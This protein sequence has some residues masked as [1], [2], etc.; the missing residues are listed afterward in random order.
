MLTK[1]NR[2]MNSTTT[3]YD[4]NILLDVKNV[5][6]LT[7]NRICRVLRKN[8]CLCLV[9]LKITMQTLFYRCFF[10]DFKNILKLHAKQFKVTNLTWFYTIN[11]G[12]FWVGWP[13]I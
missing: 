10:I 9:E 13:D 11:L 3:L 4:K 7:V 12:V 1:Y 6:T 5:P 2:Y 8:V